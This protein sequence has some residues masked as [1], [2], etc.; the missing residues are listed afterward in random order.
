M[1]NLFKDIDKKFLISLMIIITALSTFMIYTI[2][3]QEVTD[4]ML[5]TGDGMANGQIGATGYLTIN[6]LYYRYP[7]FCCSKGTPLNGSGSATLVT[8][9]GSSSP[10]LTGKLKPGSEGMKQF[11]QT[12][13]GE[14]TETPFKAGTYTSKTYGEYDINKET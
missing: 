1:R 7:I 3:A 4:E 9:G 5:S 14:N 8:E 10:E 6:D 11:E 2:Y 13:E 12:I